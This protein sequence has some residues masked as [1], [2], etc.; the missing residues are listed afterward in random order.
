MLHTATFLDIFTRLYMTLINLQNSLVK[1]SSF[2][3]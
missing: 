3:L 1:Q 2:E